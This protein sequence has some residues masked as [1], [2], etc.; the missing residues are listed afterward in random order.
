MCLPTSTVLDTYTN[1]KNQ[2]FNLIG[3]LTWS[4]EPLLLLC[5]KSTPIQFLRELLFEKT[6]IKP[7]RAQ[8]LLNIYA[9]YMLRALIVASHLGYNNSTSLGWCSMW[10]TP[11]VIVIIC[12]IWLASPPS[13]HV[14]SLDMLV[15]TDSHLHTHIQPYIHINTYTCILHCELEG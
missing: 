5:T 8:E 15:C 1:N 13:T 11:Y 7:P 14:S 12:I 2:C 3:Q 6:A 9:P 4:L 10:Y